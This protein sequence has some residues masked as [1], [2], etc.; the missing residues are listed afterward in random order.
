MGLIRPDPMD[1]QAANYGS[2]NSSQERLHPLELSDENM[3][4]SDDKTDIIPDESFQEEEIEGNEI[5]Y[6]SELA[7]E[8]LGVCGL[9]DDEFRQLLDE[10][11]LAIVGGIEP[12]LSQ[13]GS[14]GCYFTKERNSVSILKWNYKFRHFFCHIAAKTQGSDN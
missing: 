5:K 3:A 13:K 11:Q 7:L 1:K 9:S 2:I 8:K 4:T 10:I 6:Q 12:E 14:S